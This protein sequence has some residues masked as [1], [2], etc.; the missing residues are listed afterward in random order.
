[1]AGNEIPSTKEPWVGTSQLRQLPDDRVSID[2]SGIEQTAPIVRRRGNDEGRGVRYAL[3][4]TRE[5][6]GATP[7]APIP[8]SDATAKRALSS[9]S[10]IILVRCARRCRGRRRCG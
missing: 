2:A 6:T 9:Y 7:G 3:K 1:V 8:A 10:T 5:L 4:K